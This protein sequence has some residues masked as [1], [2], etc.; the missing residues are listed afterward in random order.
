[1]PEEDDDDDEGLFV[2][3]PKIAERSAKEFARSIET[4]ELYKELRKKG[5]GEDDDRN[6]GKKKSK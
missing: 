2:V 5:T 1:M 4:G 6:D 3:D